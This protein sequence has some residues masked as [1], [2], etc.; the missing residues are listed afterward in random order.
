MLFGLTQSKAA[1]EPANCRL[2]HD[3]SPRSVAAFGCEENMAP[4]PESIDL[5]HPE[6]SGIGALAGDVAYE[7]GRADA[8]AL[9]AT[10]R[11]TLEQCHSCC[12]DDGADVAHVTRELVTAL[13]LDGWRRP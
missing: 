1:I 7:K 9:I 8:E 13:L 6:R 5:D 3:R 4:D 2:A 12:L 11:E 10:V